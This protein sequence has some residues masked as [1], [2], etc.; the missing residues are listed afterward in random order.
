MGRFLLTLD[1]GN[2]MT[3]DPDEIVASNMR[4]VTCP[5]CGENT[6]NEYDLMQHGKAIAVTIACSCGYGVRMKL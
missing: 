1:S 6:A 4:E 3:A 2:D 5:S